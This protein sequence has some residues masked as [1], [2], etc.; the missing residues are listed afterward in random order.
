MSDAAEVI[1]KSS[2][3]VAEFN[4][5]ESALAE[6][7]TRYEGVVYDIADPEQE[8]QAKSDK[9]AIGKV[10]AKLDRT[11]KEVKAPLKERVDLLDGER[12]RIKDQ[13][14]ELQNSIKNQIAEHEARIKA[15]KDALLAK[16]GKLRE[17]REFEFSPTVEQ[18]E[19]RI[20]SLK[21]VVIDD[22]YGDMKAYAALCKEESLQ[23]LEPML[24]GLKAIAEQ[25]AEEERQRKEAEEKARQEREERIAREAKEKAEREA[26]EAAERAEREAQERIERERIAKE[27]AEKREKEAKLK[28]ERDAKAAAERAEREKQEAIERARAEEQRKAE[29][30]E[31]ERLAKIAAEEEAQRKREAN[32]RHRAKINN[33]AVAALVGV[34]LS[35]ED[36]KNVVTAI[37]K[38]Q[39][40]CVSIHY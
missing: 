19:E 14:L 32:K 27:Q 20:A 40:P 6:Y 22:S 15:E 11:H 18:V 31:A 36:A 8:K 24:V 28:A 37:A 3:Q 33:E 34:G 21:A 16:A 26:K 30:A 4:E 23:V 25:K 13:L 2:G 38:H 12:K 1:E 5:F 10:I 35:E 39:I 9:L 29:Q 7:K 17:M